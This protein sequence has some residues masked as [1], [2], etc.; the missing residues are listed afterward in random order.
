MKLYTA[1]ISAGL[2]ALTVSATT[3]AAGSPPVE[4][5]QIAA[6]KTAADHEAI[7]K[8]YEQEAI[9]LDKS[10][11]MH[12]RMADTYRSIGKGGLEAANA[13]CSALAKNLA[14]AAEE[15][16]TLAAEHHKMAEAAGH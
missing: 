8:A 12:Q 5:A 13:H 10:A 16:R 7:A 15:S 1:L 6:A 2:L 11:K 14:A 3:M 4:P 9:D